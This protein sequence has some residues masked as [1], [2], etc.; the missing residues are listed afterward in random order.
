ML[1]LGFCPTG[2][3]DRREGGECFAPLALPFEQLRGKV[4][5]NAAGDAHGI[6]RSSKILDYG[7]LKNE[8]F[9]LAPTLFRGNWKL[10]DLDQ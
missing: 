6:S 8:L 3:P 5:E 7:A 4:S 2:F 9:E 10:L 1:N